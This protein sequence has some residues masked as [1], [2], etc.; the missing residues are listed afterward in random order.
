MIYENVNDQ[1]EVYV[2]LSEGQFHQVS[3][4]NGIATIGGGTHVDYVTD[5]IVTY[6]M[7]VFNEEFS[8]YK[9]T[10]DDVK[11]NLWVFVSAVIDNP[12]FDSQ[13]KE[14]LTTPQG[15]LLMFEFSDMFLYKVLSCVFGSVIQKKKER[16][17]SA[18]TMSWSLAAQEPS[19]TA[20]NANPPPAAALDASRHD[21]AADDHALA[22]EGIP[23]VQDGADAGVGD[24]G[25]DVV[26][27]APARSGCCAAAPRRA[28]APFRPWA[29][30]PPE[31]VLLIAGSFGL[32]LQPYSS[33]RGV[34]TA[35]RAAL[36]LPIPPFLTVAITEVPHTYVAV[37]HVSALFLPE[38]RSFHPAALRGR[39]RCV[40]ASDGWLA[41]TSH[42]ETEP[43]L[44]LNPLAGG[45]QVPLLSLRSEGE[46]VRKIVFAP[47][48]EP[49]D[50]AAVAICGMRR[51]AYT[52]TGDMKWMHVAMNKG[53]QLAD[54][55]YDADAGK[56]YCV[57]ADGDVHV[58]HVPNRQRQRPLVEPLQA[59]RGDLPFDPAAVYAPPL[60][61]V[62]KFTCGK[63]IFFIAGDPYQVWRN[64]TGA[65]ISM[66]VPGGG[67][68]RMAKDAVFVLKHDPG[69]RPCWDAV[70]DLGGCSVF[71][72]KNNPVVLKPADFPP[73]VR[74]NCVYWIDELCESEPMVFD[75]ATET[76]MPLLPSAAKALNPACRI[77]CWYFLSAD[78]NGRKRSMDG[79]NHGRVR[80]IPRAI[81]RLK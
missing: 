39:C 35:W 73:A 13:T 42:W 70:K 57:T 69:R 22:D 29:D 47:D 60:D 78:T 18:W 58:L 23:G 56:V 59:D 55:A 43:A 62:S 52:K 1:W 72:G 5:K 19:L 75:M 48:P 46:P 21:P 67:R 7:N 32:P 2:S 37:T 80:K 33:V 61:T 50:Y 16:V 65:T 9:V 38:E 40:G 20:R 15:S 77:V 28:M 17:W 24:G 3:L 31:L 4:V 63:N 27:G 25:L 81:A 54:L 11:S 41:V 30:L 12:E 71:V 51:L 64:T 10:E 36:P 8:S 74:G 34:C 6:V 26:H 68:F 76:S 53:D 79:E 66:Q 49:D 45:K 14:T 44:L